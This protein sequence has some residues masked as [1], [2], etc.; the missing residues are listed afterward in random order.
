M[1]ILGP[2]DGVEVEA[3]MRCTVQC[4]IAS[5]CYFNP[6]PLTDA[7]IAGGLLKR[8]AAGGVFVGRLTKTVFSH[9]RIIWDCVVQREPPASLKP[10][11]PKL[12]LMCT[13]KLEPNFF[14]K[15]Q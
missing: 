3:F 13:T 1:A 5:Q 14:Y 2:Q 10:S 4:N 6:T 12:Y 9:A 7:Q 8:A 11:K 15:L